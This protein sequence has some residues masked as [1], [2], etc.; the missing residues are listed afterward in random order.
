MVFRDPSDQGETRHAPTPTP[1][2]LVRNLDAF[3]QRWKDSE[4]DGRKIL[5]A[6]ALS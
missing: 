2:I 6:A 5:S 3:L 1:P 4:Y